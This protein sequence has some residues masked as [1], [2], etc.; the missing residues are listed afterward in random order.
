MIKVNEALGY[1]LSRTF[2]MFQ[3]VLDASERRRTGARAACGGRVTDTATSIVDEGSAGEVR[4]D[5]SEAPR[6]WSPA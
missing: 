3:R 5:H 1:R 6:G 2:A 4:P